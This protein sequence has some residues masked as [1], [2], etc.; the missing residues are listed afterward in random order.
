MIKPSLIARIVLLS[1]SRETSFHDQSIVYLSFSQQPPQY[2]TQPNSISAQS[3]AIEDTE[4]RIQ[5]W[6]PKDPIEGEPKSYRIAYAVHKILN[7]NPQTTQFIGLI[8]LVSAAGHALVIPDALI[9]PPNSSPESTETVILAY[10]FLPRG[11]GAGFATESVSAVL[12]AC[13]QIPNF[14]TPFEKVY[15]RGVVNDG[16]PASLKVMEKLGIKERGVFEWKGKI[17]LAGGWRYEDRLHI[18][19]AYIL[20]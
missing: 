2:L 7:S 17:W 20:E 4:K 6:L 13:K 18:S 16:N 12:A 19:G 8:T 10:S 5:A 15:V 3:K 1:F 11:W 9:L 14:W